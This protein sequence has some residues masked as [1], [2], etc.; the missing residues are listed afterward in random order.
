[1]SQSSNP[2]TPRH[3]AGSAV[4][5]GTLYV[6]SG[7][8]S[9][10]A[11]PTAELLSLSLASSF[12]TDTAPWKL[13]SSGPESG[14]AR[15]APA[16]DL[17]TFFLVG[18]GD[19]G[20][21]LAASYDIKTNV[22]YYSPSTSVPGGPQ[23]PRTSAGIALDVSSGVVVVFGGY[24]QT[25]VSAELDLIDS[26]LTDY[27]T[28]SW[29]VASTSEHLPALYQPIVTYLPNL[30]STLVM[31]GSSAYSP[32]IGASGFQTFDTGYLITTSVGPTAQVS[33]ARMNGPIPTP[34]LSPCYVVL[35]NGNVFMYGGAG[36]GGTLTDAWVLD[37]SNFSWS[38]V[39]IQ[40]APLLGRAGATCQMVAP[41][42][43]IIVGGFTGSLTGSR[44]FANPQVGVILTDSWTWT[45]TYL[46]PSNGN[47]HKSVILIVG[48]TIASFLFL[49]AILYTLFRIFRRRKSSHKRT[50]NHQSQSSESSDRLL[51]TLG[52]T[53]YHLSR[54]S[55]S[56]RDQSKSLPLIITPYAPS[57]SATSGT[58][59]SPPPSSK[60]T[61]QN[62]VDAVF[63]ESSRLPK[64]MADI[65]YSHYVRTLQHGKQ[66][67]IRRSEL[68][69]QNPDLNKVDTITQRQILLDDPTD[70]PYVVT[71]LLELKDV[72]VGEEP[73]EIPMQ[74]I[75]TGT[76]LVSSHLELEPSHLISTTIMRPMGLNASPSSHNSGT[77]SPTN[78]NPSSYTPGPYIPGPY[79]PGTSNP[80]ASGSSLTLTPSNGNQQENPRNNASVAPVTTSIL[81]EDEDDDQYNYFPGVGGPITALKAAKEARRK[82]AEA[83]S[84]KKSKGAGPKY[85]YVPT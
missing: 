57:E 8:T 45:Q 26:R 55:I 54:S 23:T 37:T 22:W 24:T 56:P 66:Y 70:Q 41:N 48:I 85:E 38:T 11:Q 10:E 80:R 68:V 51:D 14:D 73:V 59:T 72:D 49:G 58:S 81:D 33:I 74:P 40:D 19:A 20:S 62:K 29:T 44:D 13:L 9:V 47:K 77:H 46:L 61:K 42:Q 4:I 32:S 28:L 5:N 31:G 3:S 67:D 43:I 63:P 53:N 50:E 21:P 82:A 12:S 64:T 1:M 75:G 78:Y 30:K 84:R 17:N 39:A 79:I 7:S 15:V 27:N 16:L 69:K 36:S 71:A 2:F 25:S 52:S 34:R 18:M 83:E 76:M 65:Q 60:A 6:V 35:S